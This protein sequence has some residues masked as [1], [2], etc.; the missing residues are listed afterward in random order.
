MTIQHATSQGPK[1][2][3]PARFGF[4]VVLLRGN[5]LDEAAAHF[6]HL[7]CAL[8]GEVFKFAPGIILACCQALG[9]YI[10]AHQQLLL[11]VQTL[12]S[13]RQLLHFIYG[14]A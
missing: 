10:L 7:I 9:N 6:C 13:F 12:L 2:Q 14:A 11:S 1:S 4:G 5:P 8:T 3:F